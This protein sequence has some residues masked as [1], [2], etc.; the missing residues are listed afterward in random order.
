MACLS[1]KNAV[2]LVARAHAENRGL[3]AGERKRYTKTIKRHA[4]VFQ[5]LIA[6]FYD[7]DAFEVF[8][9]QK[10]PWDLSPGITSIVAGHAKMTWPL[11]WRFQVFLFV[12]RLQRYW[13]VVKPES[14]PH[15]QMAR[16]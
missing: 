7:D 4:G 2:E 12:C 14:P 3:T 11:W 9:C 16:A 15:H 10:V 1:A 6:A 5:K 13:K 8:L